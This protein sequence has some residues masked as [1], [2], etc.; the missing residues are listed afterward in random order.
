[1]LNCSQTCALS[2][3]ACEWTTANSVAA[4]G[5]VPLN[6]ASYSYVDSRYVWKI[7]DEMRQVDKLL[8]ISLFTPAGDQKAGN[9][10]QRQVH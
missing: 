10:E 9:F 2:N 1:M 3:D 4:R 5:D 7:V 8:T 6:C